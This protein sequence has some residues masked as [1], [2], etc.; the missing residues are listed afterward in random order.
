MCPDLHSH[1]MK[2][3]NKAQGS[4]EAQGE[5]ARWRGGDGREGGNERE[6]EWERGRFVVVKVIVLGS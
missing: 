4:I 3:L 2:G 5:M 6:R 1:G